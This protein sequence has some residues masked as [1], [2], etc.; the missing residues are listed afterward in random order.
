MSKVLC[1]IANDKF[2][3]GLNVTLRSFLEHNDFEGD[4]VVFVNKTY[5]SISNENN[6]IIYTFYND[7]LMMY[8]FIV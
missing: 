1:T 4:I 7:L 3:D 8:Y 6:N 5:A 2:V